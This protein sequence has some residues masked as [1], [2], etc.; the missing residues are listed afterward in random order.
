MDGKAKLAWV[1]WIVVALLPPFARVAGANNPVQ[2]QACQPDRQIT[3]TEQ[4]RESHLKL[5]K[6]TGLIGISVVDNRGTRLGTVDEIVLTPDRNAIDYA[7]V[8]YGGV[9]GV[10][11]KLFAVPWSQF[12]VRSREK[13][14]ALNGGRSDVEKA[15]GLDRNH[16]PAMAPANWF[17]TE[18]NL[19]EPSQVATPGPEMKTYVG[20]GNAT[21]ADLKYRRLSGLVGLPVRNFQ[22]E[23]LGQL[24]NIMI[25][26]HQGNVAYGIVS[27][28]SG[29]LG[30]N[31]DLAAVPWS[32]IDFASQPGIARL[33]A[34]RQTLEAIAFKASHFPNLEDTQYSRQLYERFHATP[35]WE[36]LGYVPAE[37]MTNEDYRSSAAR[38]EDSNYNS[39]FSPSAVE[40][41]R[42]TVV[43]V[44]TFRLE[45]TSIRG[46][47]LRIKTDD[48]NAVTVHTGPRSYIENQGIRF[49]HG[50]QVTVTGSPEK[51]GRRNFIVA[52][53]ITMGDKA[54]DLR[55]REG[56]PL[57]NLDELK[58]SKELESPDQSEHSGD[59][60]HAYEW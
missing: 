10:H 34:D 13:A 20:H 27:M 11:E 30:L 31:K 26:V 36:T 48:G 54:L 32:A 41:I 28:R 22:G 58:N 42:G 2:P 47:R 6:A 24:A 60:G 16:W 9:W 49:H 18:R 57:W 33:N 15:K 35:Y 4:T 38:T 23:K 51:V 50:D 29:F 45:G 39:S 21:F 5:E 19:N 52:S 17:G 44:G 53:Q 37:N 3:P 1:G 43:S 14:L 7:V 40:T 59:L 25:D 12:Q 55:T 56:K 8:S 46:L